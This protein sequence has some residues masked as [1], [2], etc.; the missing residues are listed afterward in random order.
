MGSYV[1]YVILMGIFPFLALLFKKVRASVAGVTIVA[2]AVLIGV[3]FERY[4]MTV[5]ALVHEETAASLPIIHP[6][7]ILFTLG[8]MSLFL[9]VTLLEIRRRREILPETEEELA[10]EVLIADPMGWQ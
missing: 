2:G 8:V 1:A 4:V 7:N 5:P 9:L 10:R 6:I 3:W